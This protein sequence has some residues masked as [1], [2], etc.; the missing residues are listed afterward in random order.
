MYIGGASICWVPIP[1]VGNPGDVLTKDTVDWFPISWQPAGGGGGGAPAN[2]EYV[3][4]TPN[5]VL[6]QERVLDVEAT[7]LTL[8]DNGA[9]LTVEIGVATNGITLAKLAQINQFEFLARS[10]A[11][12]GNVQALTDAQVTAILDQFTAVLQGLVPASGGGTA[13]FLRADGTWAVPPGAGGFAPADAQY[14]TLATDGTLT[15]E[16]TL[17]VEAAVLTLTDGGAG[18]PVTIAVATNGITDAKLRQGAAVS[19]IGRSINSLGNVA[20]IAAGAND[21]I[22]RRTADTLNFGQLTVGMAPNDLWTYD[23]LQN[24]SALSVLGRSP[25]SIGD[26]ADIVAGANDLILRRV[27]DTIDFG[28]LTVGM[29]ANDLWTYAKIQNVVNNNRVLG[30]V[31]GAGGD[32]EELT[33]AQLLTLLGLPATSQV[34]IQFQDE[35][36]ALGTPATADVVNFVGAGVVASRAVN[37]I[38]V[39]ISG[40]GGGSFA[41]TE[42]EVDFG[43]TPRFDAQFS[44]ADGTV[45]PSSKVLIQESGKA[46]TGRVTGDSQ[47]DSIDVAALPAAGSFIAYC[48]ADPGPVVGR[49]LLQYAVA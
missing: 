10:A 20:D 5:G 25:N 12:L 41:M 11:G 7:V 19:V 8:T 21:T 37:T 30:R 33:S 27:A 32:I 23:K 45:A 13:N 28:Q 18:N 36:V 34:G 42:V 43:S 48:R 40:G 46:A 6:T 38:T 16:R 9:G 29:A 31:S 14:V 44:I 15:N 35:G 39:T 47:W 26:L 2:A 1:A 17:A 3:V 24:A 4:L 49:R 22:F